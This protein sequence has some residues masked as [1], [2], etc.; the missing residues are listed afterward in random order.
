[1]NKP[2]RKI[3]VGERS[4]HGAVAP[5]YLHFCTPECGGPS[6]APTG[7]GTT[8]TANTRDD[9]RFLARVI[10]T[11]SPFEARVSPVDSTS[12]PLGMR[13]DAPTWIK[14]SAPGWPW[15]LGRAAYR[16][17]PHGNARRN[18]G[19]GS[20]EAALLICIVLRALPSARHLLVR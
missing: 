7:R 5:L 2:G 4:P 3:S 9:P 8:Q 6:G 18:R 13:Q 17:I 20:S 11:E 14:C 15:Y 1:M 10:T 19:S 12:C 16:I